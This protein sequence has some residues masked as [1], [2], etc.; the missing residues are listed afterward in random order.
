MGMDH[1]HLYHLADKA[2]WEECKASQTA[3]YPPTYDQDGFIHLTAEPGLLL[4]VANQFYKAAPGDWLV[5]KLDSAKLKSE[6]G[7]GVSL[8]FQECVPQGQ[9]ATERKLCAGA[10]LQFSW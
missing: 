9:T 3:Y 6:V 1:P 5:L 8:G 10:C 4:D 2:Q 7:G